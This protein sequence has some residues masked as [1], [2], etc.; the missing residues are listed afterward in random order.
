LRIAASLGRL[1][2]CR[3]LIDRYHADINEFKEGKGLPI[4]GEAL[5]FTEVVRLLIERGAD[6]KTRITYERGQQVWGIGDDA[7]ILHYAAVKGVPRTINLL[8]D[9]GLDIF[10]ANYPSSPKS[11]VQTALD[12]AVKNDKADN[13][14]AILNHSH[15]QRVD[16]NLRKTLLGRCL[17]AAVTSHGFED[18]TDERLNI[19]NALLASGADPNVSADGVTAVQRAANDFAESVESRQRNIKKIIA[20]L[21]ARGATLDIYSAATAG[22]EAPVAQLLKKNPASANTTGPDGT[23]VLHLAVCMNHFKIVKLLLDAGVDV[24]SHS[25]EKLYLPGATALHFAA[26]W[27][28]L[29]LAKLLLD[30]GADINARD[31]R[32]A[33]PLHFAATRPSESIARLLLQRGADVKAADLEGKTPLDYCR[34]MQRGKTINIEKLLLE[35][36]HNGPEN[37]PVRPAK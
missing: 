7:T 29:E 18:K 22:D 15:F 4:I 32:G 23:P 11:P 10:T 36:D 8:I 37:R 30:R 21:V 27:G 19:V 35:F 3:L 17:M 2:I 16:P 9:Q 28:R 6:L 33:T 12:L 1:D 20:A 14:I 31:A 25:H 34:R 24:N 5:A 13:A 26:S